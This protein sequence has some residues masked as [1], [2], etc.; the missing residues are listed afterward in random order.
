MRWLTREAL[1]GDLSW[2][3]QDE[4]WLQ[5]SEA[6][7]AVRSRLHSGAELVLDLNIQDAVIDTLRQL[8]PDVVELRFL[9]GDNKVGY[10]WLVLQYSGARLTI[11][12]PGFGSGSRT[13]YEILR[14]ELTVS[15]D[16]S[17]VHSVISWPVGEFD[18]E[19]TAVDVTRAPAGPGARAALLARAE[20][21]D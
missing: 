21:P 6:R 15:D 19:F 2:E 3:E 1:A 16:S 17:F 20:N 10:E 12:E 13:A 14:D 11:I 4:R 18:V 9:I 8:Q 5:W 7:H